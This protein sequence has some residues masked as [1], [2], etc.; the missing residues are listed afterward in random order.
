MAC[1]AQPELRDSC[2][3]APG[4]LGGALLLCGARLQGEDRGTQGRQ[5][6]CPAYPERLDRCA[7]ALFLLGGAL[8][9]CGA[10]GKGKET[11]KRQVAFPTHPPIRDILRGAADRCSAARDSN[12]NE[13]ISEIRSR[14]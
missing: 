7:G 12:Q 6:A 14:R 11:C 13:E 8:L 5:V 4:L 1:P 2:A 3:C 9:S 10:R